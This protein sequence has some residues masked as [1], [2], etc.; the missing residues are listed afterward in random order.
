MTATKM[1]NAVLARDGHLCV[2]RGPYCTIHATVADHRANRGAG[3][4]DI[5]DDPAN[6]IASCQLCNGFKEDATGDDRE[7]LILRGI[8]VEKPATNAGALVK[9]RALPVLYPDGEYRLLTSDGK[10]TRI[11]RGLAAELFEV[12]GI[13]AKAVA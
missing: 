11:S 13:R 4:S 3:G 8:R 12:Y 2:I 10:R 1:I 6:L 5:L 9:A 7:R